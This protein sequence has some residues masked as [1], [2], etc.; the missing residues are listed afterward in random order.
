MFCTL[1]INN[2]TGRAK[3]I[4]FSP[5]HTNN[6]INIMSKWN[7]LFQSITDLL[8]HLPQCFLIQLDNLTVISQ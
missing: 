2:D 7:L 6:Q 4:F 3:K 1:T 8:I 5:P